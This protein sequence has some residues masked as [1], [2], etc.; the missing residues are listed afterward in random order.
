M[1]SKQRSFNTDTDR[2]TDTQ[3]RTR[4]Q[5][6][7]TRTRCTG[8]LARSLWTLWTSLWTSHWT[9][10]DVS[11]EV[12]EPAQGPAK[13]PPEGRRHGIQARDW[14]SGGPLA[15]PWAS[16]CTPPCTRTPPHHYPV[17]HHPPLPGTP[18][19]PLPVPHHPLAVPAAP[20]CTS[21][22]LTR[23]PL[24]TLASGLLGVRNTDTG[25][26]DTRTR[27]RFLIDGWKPALGRLYT[28]VSSLYGGFLSVLPHCLVR[29]V[30]F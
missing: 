3:T 21:R 16:P 26:T 27:T 2:N 13:G 9:P 18:P 8:S 19:P 11:M 20:R 7:R 6:T 14:P 25:H 29:N 23:L 5:G 1:A 15:G 28:V 12:T 4:T 10:L 24:E 22:A 17:H 30:P